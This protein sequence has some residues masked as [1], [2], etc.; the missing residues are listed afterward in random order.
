MKRGFTPRNENVCIVA[1]R[2]RPDVVSLVVSRNP[3]RS[4]TVELTAPRIVAFEHVE[5][6]L[7][8]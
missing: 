8:S 7:H 2:S 1:P 3:H 6:T 4:E 5:Q